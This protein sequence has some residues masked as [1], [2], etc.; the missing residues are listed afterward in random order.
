MNVS[1]HTP[2]Q[3]LV[4]SAMFIAIG[5]VLP[6]LTGQIQQIGNLLLPMH[7]PVFL[8]GLILGPQYGATVGLVVPLLRSFL[9]GMPPM[10][11]VAIAMAVELAC[12]GLV[13][14]IVYRLLK[15]RD[16]L[17]VYISLVSAMILG[18]VMW[19]LAQVILLGL[20]NNTFTWQ[21]FVAGAFANAIPGIIVQMILI[22]A[23]M[24]ALH[25]AGVRRDRVLG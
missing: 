19:G 22:P 17:G 15:R 7:L 14:G 5:L 13:I 16:A 10:Y 12:Y 20:Q 11:P 1:K 3:K 4:L 8:C 25:A 18:R 6:F 2:L 24:S 21:M 9:F 23:I